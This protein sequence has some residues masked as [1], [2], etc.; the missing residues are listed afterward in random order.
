MSSRSSPRASAGCSGIPKSA[1]N[2]TRLELL[3]I[4]AAV[5]T[6]DAM[7]CQRAIAQK[8]V[9]GRADDI[10]AL[11]GN[12][13]TLRDDVELFAGEQK[14]VGFRDAVVS[15]GETIRTCMSAGASALE[16]QMGPTPTPSRTRGCQWLPA[17]PSARRYPSVTPGWKPLRLSFFVFMAPQP[18]GH[19]NV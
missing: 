19:R 3:S 7:R 12:Q 8:I 10:L 15:Q 9:E 18:L 4:D 16:P 14:A 2:S 5:V 1:T 6:I 13:G 11:K 17:S